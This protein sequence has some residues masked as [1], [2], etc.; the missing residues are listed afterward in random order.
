MINMLRGYLEQSII[1]VENAVRKYFYF[2]PERIVARK[3]RALTFATVLDVGCGDGSFLKI[4]K[5]LIGDRGKKITYIGVDI[6]QP[7]LDL[8]LKA[9][10]YDYLVRADANSLPFKQKKIDIVIAN[11][12]VEHVDKNDIL[13]KFE[14]IAGALLIVATPNGY[15]PFC[16]NED[17]AIIC[18]RHRCGYVFEDFSRRGYSI[19][20]TGWK[21]IGNR[22]YR[23]GRLPP[24]IRI[25][26]TFLIIL[27]TVLSYKIPRMANCFICLK[28]I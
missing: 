7:H 3:L 17:T 8:S 27:S 1:C 26:T 13:A 28:K 19:Y 14:R 4:V 11:Q 22:I 18:Q 5:Q 2:S 12:M 25:A 10:C 6:Y 24:P 15:S 9:G 16:P 20:G 21:L 23:S